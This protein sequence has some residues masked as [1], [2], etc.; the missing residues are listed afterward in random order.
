MKVVV[1]GATGHI[2]SYL[3]PRLVAD[4][5]EVVALSRGKRRPYLEHRA[6]EQVESVQV[7]RVAEEVLGTFG[8]HVASMRP[9]AVVDLLCFTVPSG[10]QLLE[11]LVPIGSYLLHCGTIWVHGSA[12]EVPVTEDVVRR[13]LG[14]YG[15]Q[16]AAIEELLLDEARRGTVRCTVLHP[17][18]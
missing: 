11:A 9:D 4:G 7:D 8:E 10:R 18:H 5:H 15:V 16:K 1:V 17:G 6:W 3:V 2:G 14:D 13:P 12:V